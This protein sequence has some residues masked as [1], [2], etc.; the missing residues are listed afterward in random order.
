MT[1]S[2]QQPKP[3]LQQNSF[4]NTSLGKKK[5]KECLRFSTSQEILAHPS[6]DGIDG[7]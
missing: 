5:I 1:L 7:I 4:Y 6:V 2:V 3:M